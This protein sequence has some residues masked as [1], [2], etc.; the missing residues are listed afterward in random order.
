V[1]LWDCWWGIFLV[2][3]VTVEMFKI[4]YTTTDDTNQKNY[5]TTITAGIIVKQ[6]HLLLSPI[7]IY[8]RLVNWPHKARL[9]YQQGI[10]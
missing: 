7:I 8:D 10:I 4:S 3:V 5:T 6:K 9:V 1:D 2:V